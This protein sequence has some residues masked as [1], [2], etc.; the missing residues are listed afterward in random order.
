M[1]PTRLVWLDALPLTSS[2]KVDRTALPEPGNSRPELDTPFVAPRTPVEQKLVQVWK[3]VLCVNSVGVHDSFFDLGG[4]SL[5]ATRIISQVIMQFQLELP[6]QSLFKAPTVAEM[7]AIITKHRGKKLDKEELD[8][9]LTELES[10][11]DEDAKRL[12]TN[13]RRTGDLED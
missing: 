2:G 13:Q 9:I 1:I 7:G 10:L 8:R 3:E 11:S 6:L 5:D 12:L 4:H